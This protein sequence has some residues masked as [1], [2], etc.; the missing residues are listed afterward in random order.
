MAT[1]LDVVTRKA[2]Q[3]Y[4]QEPIP[5]L[6][7]VD[8]DSND[9]TID[10]TRFRE[11][12]NFRISNSDDIEL[13]TGHKE[14]LAPSPLTAVFQWQP[15]GKMEYVLAVTN[16]GKNVIFRFDVTALWEPILGTVALF[17]VNKTAADA[18]PN[19]I[20]GVVD[21][22]S[23]ASPTEPIVGLT[24]NQNSIIVT[25]FGDAVYEVFPNELTQDPIPDPSPLPPIPPPW[26][27]TVQQIGK[28][29]TELPERID[30]ALTTTGDFYP[31]LAVAAAA[32]GTSKDN[33]NGRL[34]TLPG[35]LEPSY[36]TWPIN[37]PYWRADSPA[38]RN[39]SGGGA[40]P[41]S[42]LLQ[43]FG[44]ANDTES[45]GWDKFRSMHSETRAWS[46]RFVNVYSIPDAK[47]NKRTVY[48]KPS[49]DMPV[50]DTYYAPA[51]LTDSVGNFQQRLWDPSR[52]D[53]GQFWLNDAD[54]A[55]NYTPVVQTL[56]QGGPAYC[57]PSFADFLALCKQVRTFLG[58]GPFW[59]PGLSQDNGGDLLSPYFFLA[60]YCG[61]RS[62]AVGPSYN[63][64]TKPYR[65]DVLASE[66]KQAPLTVFNWADFPQTNVG[67]PASQ[68][69]T[70][71]R[72]YRTAHSQPGDKNNISKDP[73]FEAHRYGYVGSIKAGGTFT[74]DISDAEAMG[75]DDFAGD[76]ST[77]NQGYEGYLK[78][79][80]SGQVVRSYNGKLALLNTKTT[81]RVTPPW[82]SLRAFGDYVHAADGNVAVPGPLSKWIVPDGDG[83][84]TYTLYV[85]YVDRDGIT[86]AP[87]RV[88]VEMNGQS[89]LSDGSTVVRSRVDQA[90]P[91]INTSL[92][93]TIILQLPRGYEE[94]I[95]AI[96][97]FGS[98][99][100]AGI[101]S[102]VALGPVGGFPPKTEAVDIGVQ[103]ISPTALPGGLPAGDKKDQYDPG[104]AI[105]S[106]INDMYTFPPLNAELFDEHSGGTGMEVIMGR[107]WVL[108]ENSTHLTTLSTEAVQELEEETKWTG[109][110]SRFAFVKYGGVVFF[111]SSAGVYYA[112]GSGVRPFPAQVSQLVRKYLTEVIPGIELMAN[113]RRASMGLIGNRHEIMLHIPSS[114]DLWIA[115]GF[116]G[117]QALPQLTVCFKFP[118]GRDMWNRIT[119]SENYTFDFTPDFQIGTQWAQVD[120]H[121]VFIPSHLDPAT[122][123]SERV[124]FCSESDGSLWAA[125]RTTGALP[126]TIAVDCDRSDILWSGNWYFE[127][128]L[129]LGLVTTP[130]Q[131]RMVAIKAVMDTQAKMLTGITRSDGGYDII[132]GHLD[133]QC[134]EWNIEID[135]PL[136]ADGYA[137]TPPGNA[138]E[139]MSLCPYIR[140]VG[141]PTSPDSTSPPGNTFNLQGIEI[142]LSLK[143]HHPA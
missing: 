38:F 92:G 99:Y 27:W 101:R 45:S 21:V 133:P 8:Y 97:V 86:S 61:W 47:G 59:T 67:D 52:L 69:L 9:S 75:G 104:E 136:K 56:E 15:V 108:C 137:H 113:A 49:A 142:Y 76:I 50:R 19:K 53:G 68:Y 100:A 143:H 42:A 25:V 102:F 129:S 31:Y 3:E 41:D 72:I 110:I 43:Q 84:P 85:A 26:T 20:L 93:G 138:F 79:D 117:S 123:H 95:T 14:Y 119:S 115:A 94:T 131:I 140:M 24:E 29:L 1:A 114:R 10:K 12:H 28:N 46:Y 57:A 5:A 77:P 60:Y 34:Q 109:A 58:E 6:G 134:Q 127:K 66:L 32:T 18:N 141:G 89:L 126:K 105:Y 39:L 11:L 80:F 107:L 2:G 125:C 135:R 106:A 82:Q 120:D 118:Q 48:G 62:G 17:L 128:P 30:Y 88:F 35:Q 112:Q 55:S 40:A 74:D 13:R 83:D 81:Y 51:Q 73:L 91:V 70:E 124:L 90:T 96:K 111:L 16:G 87:R 122:F 116:D 130:K 23:W 33:F 36:S 65:K 71:I 103:Y 63:N 22:M 132:N 37:I 64:T 139:S 4:H 98:Q 121:G 54:M 44:F 78:G 7:G